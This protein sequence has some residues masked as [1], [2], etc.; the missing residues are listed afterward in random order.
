MEEGLDQRFHLLVQIRWHEEYI[1]REYKHAVRGRKKEQKRGK[2]WN[3]EEGRKKREEKVNLF[4]LTSFTVREPRATS[5]T[6][7]KS[8]CTFIRT[9][10]CTFV[11]VCVCVCV[12]VERSL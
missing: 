4:P 1:N 7:L 2:E 3:R 9:Y 8:L 5:R 10:V 11:C 6:L 12:C